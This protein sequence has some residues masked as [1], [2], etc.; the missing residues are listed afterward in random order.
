MLGV[1]PAIRGSGTEER[2]HVVGWGV[3]NIG[4]MSYLLT[5]DTNGSI[6]VTISLNACHGTHIH[7][8]VKL[9]PILH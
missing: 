2:F 8:K 7:I 9:R 4:R 1:N 5:L 6:I 3:N